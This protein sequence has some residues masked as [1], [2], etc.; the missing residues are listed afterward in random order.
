[1]EEQFSHRLQVSSLLKGKQEMWMNGALALAASNMHLRIVKS[2]G[3]SKELVSY[4]LNVMPPF[5][6]FFSSLSL[7]TVVP[8]LFCYL[9]NH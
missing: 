3:A 6:F 5:S 8:T 2:E 9:K 7:C 4:L 1:M